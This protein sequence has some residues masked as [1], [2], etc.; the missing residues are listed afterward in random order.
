MERGLTCRVG[1]PEQDVGELAKVKIARR[2][3]A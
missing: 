1:D 2:Q 3:T